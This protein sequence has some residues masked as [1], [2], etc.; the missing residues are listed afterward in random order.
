[1]KNLRTMSFIRSDKF[2]LHYPHDTGGTYE[3]YDTYK[4]H[5]NPVHVTIIILTCTSF[6]MCS[7]CDKYETYERN[8]NVDICDNIDTFITHDMHD[9]WTP[10][11]MTCLANTTHVTFM[12]HVIILRSM[13]LKSQMALTT[14]MA[15][16]TYMMIMTSVSSCH[17]WNLWYT[18]NNTMC[19]NCNMHN[20][21][22]TM[23]VIHHVIFITLIMIT[24]TTFM[25]HMT[26]G[27]CHFLWHE[28]K[29]WSM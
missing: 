4:T 6:I 13:T 29:S 18:W 2:N 28:W 14:C 9:L 19:A 16:M 10:D 8:C 23:P 5:G 26:I 1:M 7:I 15:F 24:Y 12:T 27:M 21:Y 17:A 3:I 11:N 25:A 22:V 20:N